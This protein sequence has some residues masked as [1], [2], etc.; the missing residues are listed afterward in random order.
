M[1]YI[2]EGVLQKV[3]TQNRGRIY[4]EDLMIREIQK[5]KELQEKVDMY[6]QMFP[7][8]NDTCGAV[9]RIGSQLYT[10]YG[11]SDED[12]MHGCNYFALSDDLHIKSQAL[13]FIILGI[14][15]RIKNTHL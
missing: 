15:K 5:L 1:K 4:P 6:K 12:V 9:T 14:E 7:P 13:R 11:A 10:R 2:L 8:V 3:E